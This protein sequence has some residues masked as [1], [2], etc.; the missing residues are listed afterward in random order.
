MK[1]VL[2]GGCA[3]KKIPNTDSWW[4]SDPDRAYDDPLEPDTDEDDLD[5]LIRKEKTEWKKRISK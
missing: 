3:V 2:P 4:K 5:K 1:H